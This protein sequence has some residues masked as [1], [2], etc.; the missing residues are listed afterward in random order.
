[1]AFLD[2]PVA[3]STARVEASSEQPM[4]PGLTSLYPIDSSIP[5]CWFSSF[6]HVC[7]MRSCQSFIESNNIFVGV[8]IMIYVCVCVSV[9][10]SVC[11]CRDRVTQFPKNWFKDFEGTHVQEL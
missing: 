1:M 11:V 5:A 4:L 7:C 9:C 2:E 6:C 10:V 3:A 8:Y